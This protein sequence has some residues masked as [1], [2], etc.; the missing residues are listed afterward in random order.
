MFMAVPVRGRVRLGG[1]ASAIW[2]G[3]PDSNANEQ[4]E[5]RLEAWISTAIEQ[6][7]RDSA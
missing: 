4:I 5:I 3:P 1:P 7:E 6:N 2:I